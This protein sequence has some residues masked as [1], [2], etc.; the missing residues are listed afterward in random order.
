MNLTRT[1]RPE[2]T[3]DSLKLI[4]ENDKV[5]PKEV[6]DPLIKSAKNIF[7]TKV[8]KDDKTT[9]AFK[10]YII[11]LG[12]LGREK[13]D[14]VVDLLNN[15]KKQVNDG[16]LVLRDSDKFIILKEIDRSLKKVKTGP[17]NL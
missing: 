3:I 12:D 7:D 14:E 13:G 6:L 1:K 8:I 10:N 5:K 17:K 4:K 11:A 16:E 2:P 15:L 9:R